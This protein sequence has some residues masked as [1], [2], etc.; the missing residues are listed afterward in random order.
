MLTW[1]REGT[2]EDLRALPVSKAGEG[3]WTRVWN[4]RARGNDVT[5]KEQR[6][7]LDIRKFFHVRVVRSWHWLARESGCPVAGSVQGQF[8]QVLEQPGLAEGAIQGQ[9]V[10][11]SGWAGEGRKG[12][13]RSPDLPEL[14]GAMA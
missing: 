10:G 8:G 11:L 4:A 12:M 5:L 2:R 9:G 13:I 6:F 14:T 7:R 1:R 3:A